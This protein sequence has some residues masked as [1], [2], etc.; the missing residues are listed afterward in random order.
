M[1]S[2]IFANKLKLTVGGV[3]YWA[4][5]SSVV[6]ASEPASTDQTTFAEAAA[7]GAVDWYITVSGIVSLDANSFWR[8]MWNN[9]GDE[10]LFEIAP[11]G[12]DGAPTSTEPVFSGSCRVPA[13][14]TFPMGGEA[15]ADGSFSFS[16]V[17]F[18]AWDVTMDVA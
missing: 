2:R 7:G 5:L 1:S 18:E 17:R 15:S 3:D 13:Q 8:T 12:N 6:L 11:F 9:A 4:D 10:V 14:G 16:D